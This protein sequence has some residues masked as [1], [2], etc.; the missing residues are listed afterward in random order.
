MKIKTHSLYVNKL[1]NDK[2]S[3]M[4]RGD[5]NPSSVCIITICQLTIHTL[6]LR[7]VSD[8]GAV[9]ICFCSEDILEICWS[10]DVKKDS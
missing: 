7:R 1:I 4:D 6:L 5:I 10:Y 3:Y 8:E 9:T 2:T